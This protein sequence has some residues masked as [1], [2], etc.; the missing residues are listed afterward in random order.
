[1]NWIINV[2]KKSAKS[3]HRCSSLKYARWPFWQSYYGI[4]AVHVYNHVI[5]YKKYCNGK[6]M[7]YYILS[8]YLGH[9]SHDNAH[10]SYNAK[11]F[12]RIFNHGRH[13]IAQPSGR[14]MGCLSLVLQRKWPRYIESAL[15]MSKWKYWYTM[16]LNFKSFRIDVI[17]I[18]YFWLIITTVII[19]FVV[20]F[21]L[22]HK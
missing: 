18:F 15:Y 7:Q 22:R 13:P 2:N 9:T 8:I 5:Y 11:T 4:Q 1:M 17:W 12:I 16:L 19:K 14:A 6:V 3:S 10:T 21:R 20:A